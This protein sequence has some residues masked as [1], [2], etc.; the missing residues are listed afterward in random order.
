MLTKNA[1]TV[2]EKRYLRKDEEGKLLEDADGMFSRVANAVA[3]AEVN[4]GKSAKHVKGW[5]E[6]FTSF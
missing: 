1:L 5:R 6:S 3:E 4:Y 2:L